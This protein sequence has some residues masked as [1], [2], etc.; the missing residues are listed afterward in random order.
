M[1]RIRRFTITL[2]GDDLA[3]WLAL[4]KELDLTLEQLVK[5]AVDLVYARRSTR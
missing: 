1:P 4:A 5:E 2:T 3:R